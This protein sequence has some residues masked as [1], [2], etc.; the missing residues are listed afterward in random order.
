MNTH[1]PDNNSTGSIAIEML[2]LMP[3]LLGIILSIFWAGSYMSSRFNQ[4]VAA[5]RQAFAGVQQQTNEYSAVENKWRTYDQSS[6]YGNCGVSASTT[7]IAIALRV[8]SNCSAAAPGGI[9][10]RLSTESLTVTDLPRWDASSPFYSHPNCDKPGGQ[11]CGATVPDPPEPEPPPPRPVPFPKAVLWQIETIPTHRTDKKTS[12]DTTA[13]RTSSSEGQNTFDFAEVTYTIQEIQIIDKY[14]HI[15]TDPD[16]NP[17]TITDAGR[18]VWRIW[19]TSNPSY[20]TSHPISDAKNEPEWTLVWEGESYIVDGNALADSTAYD[21][22]TV[23]H[24]DL[25]VPASS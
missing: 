19:P 16:V 7:T 24:V 2:M 13:G 6:Q 4:V 25:I 11:E 22:T 17:Q 14:L 21:M 12:F 9:I 20:V 23:W 5:E 15:K 8:S 10:G 3:V 18:W 1:T